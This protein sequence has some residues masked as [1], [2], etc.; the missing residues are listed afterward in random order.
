MSEENPYTFQSDVYAFGEWQCQL[1][2]NA[3]DCWYTRLPRQCYFSHRF[4]R[5]FLNQCCHKLDVGWD[6]IK[7]PSQT[8]GGRCW[9]NTWKVMVFSE[10]KDPRQTLFCCKTH[11]IVAIYFLKGFRGA[12]NKSHPAL[13][14]FQQKSACLLESFQRACF[15]RKTTNFYAIVKSYGFRREKKTNTRSTKGLRVSVA[16]AETQST[17]A[18]LRRP[19]FFLTGIVLYELLT[20]TLPYCHISDKDQVRVGICCICCICW[21]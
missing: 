9:A 20:G 14:S 5:G 7:I 10:R 6:G 17:P 11:S 15:W 1:Y 16:L 4:C 19:V 18:R 8:Q 13:E 3:W 12:F 21:G 2:S